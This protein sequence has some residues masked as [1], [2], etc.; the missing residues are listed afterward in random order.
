MNITQ[1]AVESQRKERNKEREKEWDGT[2]NKKIAEKYKTWKGNGKT[3]IE[4]KRAKN[5]NKFKYS[6]K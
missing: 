1:R 3:K 6:R 4:K 2:V 5:V